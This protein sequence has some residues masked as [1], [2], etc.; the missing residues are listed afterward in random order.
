[1][2]NLKNTIKVQ[3]G[4]ILTVV[5]VGVFY[6]MVKNAIVGDEIAEC[7]LSKFLCVSYSMVSIDMGPAEEAFDKDML[8]KCKDY[9]PCR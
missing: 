8:E 5:T 3:F 4:W 1:M 7:K 6:L 2:K 9:K